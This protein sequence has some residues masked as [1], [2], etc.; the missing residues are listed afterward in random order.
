MPGQRVFVF[1][2]CIVISALTIAAMCRE[3]ACGRLDEGQLYTNKAQAEQDEHPWLGRIVFKN[4]NDSKQEAFV[5]HCVAVLLNARHVLAPASCFGGKNVNEYTYAVMFDSSDCESSAHTRMFMIEN[6]IM[7]PDYKNDTLGDDL[8][9]IRLD[10]DVSFSVFL[11]PICIPQSWEGPTTLLA[12]NVD[13]IGYEMGKNMN[14]RRIKAYAHIIDPQLCVERY[15]GIT[16]R[17]MCGY[18]NGAD[19]QLG[20]ILIGVRVEKGVPTNYYLIGNLMAKYEIFISA[21]YLFT[22][23]APYRA[24]ILDNIHPI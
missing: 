20:S 18:I 16:E 15:P 7:H 22:C 4:R 21:P 14:S 24:W 1:V 10:R 2:N 19:L 8:A 23:I 9:V 12:A 13:M 5:Y 6:I 3:E 11:Q 17:H